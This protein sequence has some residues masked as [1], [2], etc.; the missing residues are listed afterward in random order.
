MSRT[1]IYT[2]ATEGENHLNERVERPVLRCLD[3]S[4][5]YFGEVSYIWPALLG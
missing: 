2:T 4:F 1:W 3:G 5:S